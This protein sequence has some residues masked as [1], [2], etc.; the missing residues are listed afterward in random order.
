MEG[1]ARTKALSIRATA[2][3]PLTRLHL[4]RLEGRLPLQQQGRRTR[5]SIPARP[6]RRRR[7]LPHGRG[8]SARSAPCWGVPQN[9]GPTPPLLLAPPAPRDNV[10]GPCA[11]GEGLADGQHSPDDQQAPR[12]VHGG[13]PGHA[14]AV[15][16][17]SRL[18]GLP[19]KGFGVREVHEGLK[20]D[21]EARQPASEDTCWHLGQETGDTFGMV[22]GAG[23]A[24]SSRLRVLPPAGEV[25]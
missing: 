17:A 22:N 11:H 15:P 5:T 25:K 2:A 7:R 20:I 23:R 24:G 4:R 12:A 10:E 21:V 8:S 14:E 16:H 6:R 3:H 1:G 9:A 18:G 19:R 13:V